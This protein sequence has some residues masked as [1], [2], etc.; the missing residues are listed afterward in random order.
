MA[1]VASYLGDRVSRGY[2]RDVVQASPV[3]A[4]LDAME[5]KFLAFVLRAA[6]GWITGEAADVLTVVDRSIALWERPDIGSPDWVRASAGAAK[7]A[8]ETSGKADTRPAWNATRAAASAAEAGTRAEAASETVHEASRVA[9]RSG[10]RAPY[11]CDKFADELL[12][13]VSACGRERR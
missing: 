13:L 12:R 9:E 11:D 1:G 7:V 10:G 2:L 3:G 8:W 6:R 5:G 4:E